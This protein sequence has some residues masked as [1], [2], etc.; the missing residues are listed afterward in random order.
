MAS[1]RE[2]VQRVLDHVAMSLDGLERPVLNKVFPV[3]ERA[4]QEIERDLRAWR[5]QNRGG[6]TFTAARYHNAL[7]SLRQGLELLERSGVVIEAALK[8]EFEH[9]IAA[10][11]AANFRREWEHLGRI[12]EGTVQPIPLQEAALLADGKKLLWPRFESSAEKY[13]AGIG[14]RTKFHLAVSRARAETIDELTNRLQRHLP[15]VF[16]G[17]RW[18]AERL[19]RTESL[20]SYNEAHRLAVEQAH[21]EDPTIRERWDATYDFRRCP[22]CASLDGQVIDPTKG[23]K[24]VARWFTKS[25]KRGLKQHVLVIEKAP[26][27][28]CCLPGSALVSSRS[29]I[30]AVSKRWYDG[31]LVIVRTAGGHQ[32]TCTPNHPILTDRGWVAAGSLHVGSNVVCESVGHGVSTG[33]GNHQ[34]V[35]SSIEQVADAFGRSLEVSAVPVPTTPEDF[36]GD[37]RGSNVAIVWSYGLLLNDLQASVRQLGAEG[38]FDLG[39]AAQAILSGL[40]SP[41]LFNKFLLSP[42]CGGVRRCASCLSL[43]RSHPAHGDNVGFALPPGLHAGFEQQPTNDR[44][45]DSEPV[46]NGEFGLPGNVALHQVVGVDSQSFHGFV[47]NLQTDSEDY[48]ANGVVV[49]NCRCSVTAWREAWAKYARTQDPQERLAAAA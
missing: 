34:N 1:T 4:H 49:H 27:H 5:M 9:K 46:G 45:G 30:A 42:P 48:V 2:Q 22:M 10:R 19:G 28:P 40:R 6:D 26:A 38:G 41:D 47:Y 29:R 15:D 14:E 17:N 39:H 12:F 23:E 32:L 7:G 20:N 31:D 37:G 33:H 18:D 3:L 8:S 21:E 44:A 36:H 24:Y 43:F 16:R 35:P 13:A 25:K 11:S